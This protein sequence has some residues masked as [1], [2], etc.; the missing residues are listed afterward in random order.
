MKAFFGLL[1]LALAAGAW[2][3]AGT[4]AAEDL[5][6][7]EDFALRI[8][9]ASPPPGMRLAV[10]PTGTMESR[11]AFAFRG[12]DFG[13]SRTFGMDAVLVQHP[14]GSFLIDAGFGSAVDEH[15]RTIPA[16]MRATTRY[17]KGRTAAEQLRAAGVPPASLEGVILTHAHWDHVSGLADLPGVP[18]WVTRPELDLVQSDAPATALARSLGEL[19][20]RVYEFAEREYFGYDRSY[21]VHGDGAIVIVPAPGHTPGSVIVFV[22][23]PDGRRYAFVGDTVWQAEGVQRPAERP[24]LSRRLVDGNAEQVRRRIVELHQRQRALPSLLIVPAHDRRVAATLPPL[25]APAG[26]PAPA[27]LLQ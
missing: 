13:E 17:E 22:A 24:W 21:D 20:W 19:P 14:Q 26:A 12:G 4:F 1:A 16:L 11:A 5:A 6:V 27:A 23:T 2:T 3:L 18:V 8:P 25:L 10:I 15:V 9:P 7:P